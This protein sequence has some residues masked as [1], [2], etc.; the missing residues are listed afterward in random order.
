[1]AGIGS[2][3]IECQLRARR[4]VDASYRVAV[5]AELEPAQLGVMRRRHDDLEYG[6]DPVTIALEPH[7]TGARADGVPAGCRTRGPPE[8]ATVQVADVED[9]AVAIE[10]GIRRP[11]GHGVATRERAATARHGEQ[12]REPP[13]REQR[14]RILAIV[15]HVST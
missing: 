5:I 13:V 2:Q 7:A 8:R 1:V 14:S 10:R 12:R 6:G 4:H 9:E 15:S 11:A 3:R